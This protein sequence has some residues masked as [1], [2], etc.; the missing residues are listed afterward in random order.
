MEADKSNATYFDLMLI[1]YCI[2]FEYKF[3][4]GS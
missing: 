1:Y 3:L 2:N 4:V